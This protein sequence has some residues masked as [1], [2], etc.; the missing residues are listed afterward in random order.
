MMVVNCTVVKHWSRTQA[1]RAVSTAEAQN[2]AVVKGAAEGVG[3]QSM[4]TDLGLCA[5]LRVWTISN[6][7]N[8]IAWR[9]GQTRHSN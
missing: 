8:A 1:S 6:A 2:Y 5:R 4:M 9:K 3:K 7:I